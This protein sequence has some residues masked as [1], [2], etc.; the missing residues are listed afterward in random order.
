MS[1]LTNQQIDATYAGLIKTTDNAAITATPKAL[2][3][4]LGNGIPMEIGTGGIN[5]TTGT[6]DFSAATVTGLPIQPAGLTAGTGLDSMRSADSLTTTPADAS[7]QNSIALGINAIAS[8]SHATAIG[9]NTVS[10]GGLGSTAVGNSSQATGS[11]SVAL[12]YDTRAIGTSSVAIGET[13]KGDSTGSVSIGLRAAS[14]TGGDTNTVAIGTD[15]GYLST[16]NSVQIGRN[17]TAKGVQSVALGDDARVDDAAHTEAVCIGHSTRST[18]EGTV[19]L[20][21][22]VVAVNWIDS[23]TVNRLALLDYLDL[24]YADDT[25]AATGGVPLGGIYHTSGALKIRLV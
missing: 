14:L 12:G 22:N 23:T 8:Q 20:G 19:S 24:N 15:T 6:V 21:R 5:F 4:G 25:A 18:A 1:T 2:E 7:G 13:A 11:K 16:A 17:C 9:R 10:S 3:D